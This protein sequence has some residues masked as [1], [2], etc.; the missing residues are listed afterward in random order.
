MCIGKVPTNLNIGY[1][2]EDTNA[3]LINIGN[4]FIKNLD[5]KILV[6]VTLF[7]KLKSSKNEN[8]LFFF[9]RQNSMIQKV[10]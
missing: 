5:Q 3:P 7:K 6:K 10:V 1:C 4:E 2:N 9:N 8:G